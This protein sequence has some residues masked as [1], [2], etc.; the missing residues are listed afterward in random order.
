M[1]SIELE[2]QLVQVIYARVT[3]L[4][5]RDTEEDLNMIISEKI[6]HEAL[7]SEARDLIVETLHSERDKEEMTSKGVFV[8]TY[9]SI[10]DF[11]FSRHNTIADAVREAVKLLDA[12]ILYNG[13]VI[14]YDVIDDKS[15]YYVDENAKKV[16]V[17]TL[18]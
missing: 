5:G 15:A 7:T 9:G 16:K 8:Y 12:T 2:K 13:D 14:T 3:L 4:N 18:K 11:H 17:V 6:A 10:T 1:S